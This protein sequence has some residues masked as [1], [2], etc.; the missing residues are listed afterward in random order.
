MYGH[1]NVSAVIGALF[2]LIAHHGT[3]FHLSDVRDVHLMGQHCPIRLLKSNTV[4][5]L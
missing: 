2:N 4:D 5:V 1:W 3:V